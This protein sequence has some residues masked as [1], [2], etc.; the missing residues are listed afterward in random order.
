MLKIS[1]LHLNS[2]E[3]ALLRDTS[4]EGDKDL[5][6]PFSSK[7][8]DRKWKVICIHDSINR[9]FFI[10]DI[11]FAK[12]CKQVLLITK[13]LEQTLPKLSEKKGSPNSLNM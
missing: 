6:S 5:T 12:Y 8:F 7:M 11:I 4:L 1:D 2:N 3:N 10:L 9:I 13:S